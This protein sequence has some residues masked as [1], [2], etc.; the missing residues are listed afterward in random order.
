MTYFASIQNDEQE[1]ANITPNLNSYPSP[2]G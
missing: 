2:I 1:V